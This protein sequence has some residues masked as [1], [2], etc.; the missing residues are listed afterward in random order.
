VPSGE[1]RSRLTLR[2]SRSICEC[3]ICSTLHGTPILLTVEPLKRAV[4]TWLVDFVDAGPTA[5]R[6][7]PI[8]EERPQQDRVPRRLDSGCV[9]VWL[10]TTETA[11]TIELNEALTVLSSDER[12]RYDKFVFARDRR[13]Y[14]LAHALLRRTL[15][16]YVDVAPEDHRFREAAGGKPLLVSDR[17]VS[18]VTF[19]LS[20]T[21]GLV[22]CAIAGGSDVGIDVELIDRKGGHDFLDRFFCG[23]EIEHVR[24]LT[25]RIDQAR[26]FCELWTL[27][28]AFVKAT[29]EGLSN[30]FREIA[31]EVEDRGTVVLRAARG[32]DPDTWRFA[33]VG[34]ARRYCLAIALRY[35]RGSALCIQSNA[36]DRA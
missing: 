32:T 23:S 14:A 6:T 26:R 9:H 16:R 25:S 12:S 10:Q 17:S 34:T 21:N 24:R 5:H 13:D 18:R 2:D 1:L 4:E 33:L 19:S 29:G 11:D 35:E 36:G 20:H 28:E 31:F 30:E 7:V 3:P 22:A 27:K 8:I 15:S